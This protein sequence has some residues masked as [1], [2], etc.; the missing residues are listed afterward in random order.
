MITFDIEEEKALT[1]ELLN[2]SEDAWNQAYQKV[3]LPVLRSSTKNGISYYKIMKDRNMDEM[4]VFA[5]LY[6]EMLSRRTLEIYKFGC[7]VFLWMQIYVKKLI[8]GYCQKNENP[9][10]ENDTDNVSVSDNKEIWEVVEKSFSN[11]WRENPMKAY[12]YLLKKYYD[13][14]SKEISNMLGITSSNTDQIYKRAKDDMDILL[15][16]MGGNVK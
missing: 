5:M 9:V 12:V 3:V 10:S 6:E 1:R 15:Q 8:L 11:L 7:P 14:P 13:L 16:R 4:T 2:E